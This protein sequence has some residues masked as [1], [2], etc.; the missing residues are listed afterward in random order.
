M[1]VEYLWLTLTVL[2][3]GL[4]WLHYRLSK[5][6]TKLSVPL[7]DTAS[8]RILGVN[9]TGLVDEFNKASDINSKVLMYATIGFIIAGI[10]SLI[11][12]LH[13]F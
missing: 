4:G 8:V 5:Q 1:A 9:F 12:Y 6:I 2:Y 7:R 11:T 10:A 13:V 3:F